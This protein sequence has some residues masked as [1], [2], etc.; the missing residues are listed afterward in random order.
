[1]FPDFPEIL[2]IFSQN[3]C[4][5]PFVPSVYSL[6]AMR[7]VPLALSP[8]SKYN[9]KPTQLLTNTRGKKSFFVVFLF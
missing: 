5:F 6:S 3:L 4:D 1:M 9:N 8:A 2:G 7:F